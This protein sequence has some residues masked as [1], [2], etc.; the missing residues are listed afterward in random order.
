[1]G[2]DDIKEKVIGFD[3][4]YESMHRCKKN[5][6]WK[7]SVAN[8]YLN[9]IEQTLRLEKQLKDGTYKPRPPKKF[10][11]TH[12]K[13]RETVSIAFRDRVYQRS[14]ND[15]V[16]YPT[17]T[18]SFIYANMACQKGK[19]TDAAR[20]KLDEFLKRYYRKHGLNGYVLQCD[21]H[22]YY[23]NMS[24][25]VTEAAFKKKLPPEIYEMT[26]KILRQQ[27]EG[28]KG[29]NPGSQMIQ[30]AGISVLDPMDHMIKE[31]QQI[32]P[33]ERYMDDFFL[34]AETEEELIRCKEAIEEHLHEIDF[35]LHPEKTKIFPLKDGIKF[36]GFTHRLTETGKIIRIINPQNVKAERKKLRHMVNL[37]RKGRM[38]KKKVDECFEA[39]KAH[40]E[41]GNSKKLIRRME[42]FYAA[43]WKEDEHGRHEH[44]EKTEND[45]RPEKHGGHAGTDRKTAGDDRV[46]GRDGRR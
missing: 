41:K 23:P 27:Y 25:K 3:A 5:V 7:D 15:N 10:M 37:V 11:I 46:R 22:G 20:D 45:Q 14:L 19:G 6:L 32:E 39:W 4:L 17:M 40:A 38:T 2:E 36:L 26:E 12:P 9:G 8:F 30:I 13:K 29:Y 43:L 34:I 21:I 42:E 1:M 35:E 44:G 31:Q 24:H 33:Y 28:E 18:K 16:L